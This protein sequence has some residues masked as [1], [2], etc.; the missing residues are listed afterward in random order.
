MV[1]F[2]PGSCFFAATGKDQRQKKRNEEDDCFHESRISEI[3]ESGDTWLEIKFLE[4][5][6][7]KCPFRTQEVNQICP[8]IPIRNPDMGFLWW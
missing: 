8:V 7:H 2:G 3:K 6:G 5:Y 4:K 1:K